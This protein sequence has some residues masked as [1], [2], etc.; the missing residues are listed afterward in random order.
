MGLYKIWFTAPIFKIGMRWFWSDNIKT[1]VL[2]SDS[3]WMDY[4]QISPQS[5]NMK[6]DLHRS[7]CFMSHSPFYEFL[8]L[9]W[10]RQRMRRFTSPCQQPGPRW[11][12]RRSRRG[13]RSTIQEWFL[14]LKTPSRL[15]H[16]PAPLN[17]PRTV[18]RGAIHTYGGSVPPSF[19]P[20]R[21]PW[22]KLS[23]LLWLINCRGL[24]ND[25]FRSN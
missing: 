11:R 16:S 19:P 25:G 1:G 14:W 12:K 21:F 4:A 10:K 9:M 3:G 2:N 6:L 5:I 15:P 22:N 7:I 23:W 18:P 13:S 8:R 24:D 17:S 20:H